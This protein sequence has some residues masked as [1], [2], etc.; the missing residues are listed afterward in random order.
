MKKHKK[1]FPVERIIH[2]KTKKMFVYLC[3]KSFLLVQRIERM[4]YNYI[5][6]L[7]TSVY[8]KVQRIERRIYNYMYRHPV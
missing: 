6:T 8:N 2:F 1:N 7:Y 4:K 5:D 3:L